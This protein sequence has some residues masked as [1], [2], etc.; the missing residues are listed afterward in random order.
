MNLFGY[1]SEIMHKNNQSTQE[2]ADIETSSDDYASR[3][4]GKT[5]EWMLKVQRDI[6]FDLLK[7]TSSLNLLDVGGGHGQLAI[8][9]SHAGHKV[10]VLGSSESCAKRIAGII[11]SGKCSFKVGDVVNLPFPDHS[12]DTVISFRLLTHCEQWPKLI[13]ELCRVSKH[14]VII[15]YPTI[16]SMNKIAPLLFKAKKKLEGNTRTWKLFR[17]AEV[18]DVFTEQG[19]VL[20]RRK[21]QFFLP[22]VLHR[23]LK[24]RAISTAL[25]NICTS[26]GLTH[27]W[28]SPIIM[29]AVRKPETD[30]EES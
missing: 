4:A 2:T 14:S 26:L 18:R 13:E 1:R 21:G 23:A 15:D 8:P 11:N 17:H 25:E 20:V 3:F 28:G 9:L 6:T 5:G 7:N 16:Q 10:T 22:M 12:F 27:L 30:K 19:F 29:E 24:C